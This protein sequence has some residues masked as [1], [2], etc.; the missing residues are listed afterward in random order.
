[1]ALGSCST[2]L[3]G[4]SPERVRNL[5]LAASR[6]EGTVLLPGE[7]FSFNETVGERTAE[8]GYGYAPT[9][10]YG[11][12]VP[13]LGGGICQLAGTLYNAVLL[14]DLDVLERHRHSTPVDYTPLGQDATISWGA[15]DVV[16][17]NTLENPI[18]IEAGVEGNQVIVRV[19]GREPLEYDVALETEEWE[20]E[21]TEEGTEPGFEVTLYRVRSRE[22]RVVERQYLHRDYYPPFI[23][24]G[25]EE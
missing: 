15:Q 10:L 8:A 24:I 9:L 14:S 5:A 12:R 23:T 11:E 16:F 4:S 2:P 25:D 22:G 13:L 3:G 17:R 18:R 21:P 19:F 6:I 7:P 1:V 20:V